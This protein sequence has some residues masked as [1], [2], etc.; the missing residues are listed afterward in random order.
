MAYAWELKGLP[1]STLRAHVS[2]VVL[3]GPFESQDPTL[4]VDTLRIMGHVPQ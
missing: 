1:Y 3:P 4:I 2:T